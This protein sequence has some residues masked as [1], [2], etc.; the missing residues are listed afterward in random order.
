MQKHEPRQRFNDIIVSPTALWNSRQALVCILIDDIEYS[1]FA[2]I[3]RLVLY[4]IIAPHMVLALG[5]KPDAAAVIQEKTALFCLL[6]RQ[7]ESFFSPD[8]LHSLVVDED[9]L[10]AKYRGHHPVANSAVVASCFYDGSANVIL[11]WQVY[12]FVSIGGSIYT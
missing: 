7:P 8:T 10:I 9:P 11:I 12:W 5:T 3:H 6:L 2:A 1:D 4:E